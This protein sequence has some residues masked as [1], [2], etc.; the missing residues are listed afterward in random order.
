MP[1]YRCTACGREFD[2]G[3][4]IID[5]VVLCP[6]CAARFQD[7]IDECVYVNTLAVLRGQ[8]IDVDGC[9]QRFSGD[10]RRFGVRYNR[11]RNMVLSA[12]LRNVPQGLI[13]A[14]AIERRRRLGEG[15][16][17]AKTG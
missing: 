4:Y 17:N 6:D 1:R 8:D 13:T 9:L 11:V 3:A 10:L 14:I 12:V 16:G 2:R 7:I 5:N 15:V